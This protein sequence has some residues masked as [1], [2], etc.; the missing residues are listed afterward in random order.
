MADTGAD[1]TYSF[2]Q[3]AILSAGTWINLFRIFA[4]LLLFNVLGASLF[5]LGLLIT[6][7]LSA[8]VTTAIYRQLGSR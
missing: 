1:L 6:F 8:L 7:P 4:A 5:G 2:H 3:S